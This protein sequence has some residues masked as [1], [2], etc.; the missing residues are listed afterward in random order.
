MKT[1]ETY[2][3]AMTIATVVSNLIFLNLHYA[4]Y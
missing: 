4:K 1:R 3:V 2:V